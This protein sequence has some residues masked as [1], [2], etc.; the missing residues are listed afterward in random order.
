MKFVG[1]EEN[2]KGHLKIML[3]SESGW[4]SRFQDKR[5]LQWATIATLLTEDSESAR[6]NESYVGAM[7]NPRD[8]QN[9]RWI[10]NTTFDNDKP[11]RVRRKDLEKNGVKIAGYISNGR[12]ISHE[13][14]RELY[15]RGEKSKRHQGIRFQ[16]D[17]SEADVI[18]KPRT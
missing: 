4:K 15:W 6:C 9:Q 10:Q 18:V 3:D 8:I 13:M 11:T 17:S 12:F 1:G 7:R 14:R 5:H 2:S 16:R